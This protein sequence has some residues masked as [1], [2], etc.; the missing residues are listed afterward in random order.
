M[1][2]LQ[3]LYF[4]EF[5]GTEKVCVD[6]CNEMCKE[7]DVFLMCNKNNHNGE[8]I[9][10]Y[11]DKNVNFIDFNTDKNRF[12]LFYLYQISIVVDKI[13]PDIIHCHNT[14]FLEIMKYMQI[15]LKKKKPLIFTKHNWFIKKKMKLADLRVGISQ[16]T[17]NLCKLASDKEN[18]IIE[19]GINFKPCEKILNENEFNI[20]GVGRLEE[21][22][23]F[24]LAIKALK[25]VEFDYKFYILGRGIYEDKLKKLIKDLNLEEKVK[26]V[27]FVDNPWDYIFSSD[28]QLLPSRLEGFSLAL[29]E[30]I[31]YGKMVF[32]LDT[33]NHK[34]ILGDEFII[35]NSDVFL[36]NKLND[37]YKNYDKYM[38]D[39]L[40]IKENVQKY[41][42]KNVVQ[43]YIDAYKNVV[44]NF[45][46]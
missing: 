15:F 32:A 21:H 9:T 24:Q 31:Y 42:I 7:N 19:N 46:K 26:L 1:K 20:V 3:V 30:G 22:K 45:K 29:I 37:V 18:I 14:K 34:E 28:M 39:F 35:E 5:A 27:G 36:T 23:N 4:T 8:S 17:L 12:D 43:K 38:I 40:K 44:E 10:K 11:I 33:A 6:L 13:N 41:D 2:I 25:N 16:E